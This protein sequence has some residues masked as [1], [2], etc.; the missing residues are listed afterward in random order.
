[1]DERHLVTACHVVEGDMTSTPTSSDEREY[2][3]AFPGQGSLVARLVFTNELVDLAVLE[4]EG[5]PGVAPS[6]VMAGRGLPPRADVF[7]FPTGEPET[8]GV[9]RKFVVSGPTTSGSRQLDWIGGYGTWRGMSGGSVIDPDSGALIGILIEGAAE[10][11]FDRF[12]PVPVIRA[13]WQAMPRPWSFAGL[14]ARAH[15]ER[16]STGQR[17]GMGSISLF[18]GRQAAL[19][20]IYFALDSHTGFGQPLVVTGQPGAGKSAVVTKAALESE[21]GRSGADLGEGL[22]FHARDAV[23]GELCRAVAQLLDLDPELL[24]EDLLYALG[25]LTGMPRVGVIVDALDE[26]SD[27]DRIAMARLLSDLARLPWIRVVVATRAMSET[28]RFAAG[29]LL[30][31]LGA[32]STEAVN[33]VDL[34][35]TPYAD[36]DALVGFVTALLTQREASHPT[37]R[38]GAWEEYRAESGFTDGIARAISA[39]AQGNFLVA[40][41]TADLLSQQAEVVTLHPSESDMLQIPGTIAEALDKFLD[42]LDVRARTS[43]LTLLTA[44][45]YARGAGVTDSGWLRFASALGHPADAD[46]LASLR[47]SAAIDFLV[48][49]VEQ[50]A[51][52]PT[53][54]LFHQALADELLARRGDRVLDDQSKI[55]DLLMSAWQG[56]SQGPDLDPYLPAHLAVHAARARHAARLLTNLSRDA[57][58][59]C[60]APSVSTIA[61]FHS[62]STVLASAEM[63]AYEHFL[64]HHESA[65]PVQLAAY[66][67]YKAL[68]ADALE[69]ATSAQRAAVNSPWLPVWADSR[70]LS[71]HR[72]LHRSR[73]A[74]AH[75]CAA[76]TV[77]T[78]VVVIAERDRLTVRDL[79]YGQVL[80]QQDWNPYDVAAAFVGHRLNVASSDMK[81]RV[82]VWPDF[83]RPIELEA[84][85]GDHPQVAVVE[86][87]AGPVF[88][89]AGELRGPDGKSAGSRARAWDR[90]GSPLWELPLGAGYPRLAP[91]VLASTPC[92]LVRRY[93]NEREERSVLAVAAETGT[94]VEEWATPD[95]GAADFQV[96][97]GDDIGLRVLTSE[98]IRVSI[99]S[100][101]PDGEVERLSASFPNGHEPCCV[102]FQEAAVLVQPEGTGLRFLDPRDLSDLGHVHL[103]VWTSQVSCAQDPNGG[104]ALLTTHDDGSVRR[105]A[106]DEL[107]ALAEPGPPRIEAAPTSLSHSVLHEH[108]IYAGNSDRT[109]H[110]I[111]ENGESVASATLPAMTSRLLDVAV[112]AG[113]RLMA[114]CPRV[115]VEL[116]PETLATVG[117]WEGPEFD[118]LEDFDVVTRNGRRLLVTAGAAPAR[119]H[120]YGLDVWTL[121]DMTHLSRMVAAAYLDKKPLA[122]RFATRHGRLVIVSGGWDGRVTVWDVEQ[123]PPP[124]NHND[125]AE[126]F[127]DEVARSNQSVRSI[128]VHPEFSHLVAAMGDDG[129][130]RI[131]DLDQGSE[132]EEVNRYAVSHAGILAASCIRGSQVIVGGSG[133]VLSAWPMTTSGGEVHRG[134]ATPSLSITL[135]SNIRDIVNVAGGVV[136]ATDQGAAQ[137]DLR[138]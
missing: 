25:A 138:V 91:C 130:V 44:L 20:A 46:A 34:D 9:W 35:A 36:R 55:A 118:G 11:G 66:L 125:I 134:A 33:L 52:E 92:V 119:P 121:D 45:A 86:T 43:A 95:V 131:I 88:I 124:A 129:F 89:S 97:P 16:R 75:I 136:V 80:G 81:G 59:L 100:L 108:F 42:R 47:A 63:R 67:R 71:R 103:G 21:R 137:L 102:P 54:A 90:S 3:V 6:A 58:F 76:S 85:C 41:L 72:V 135:G 56:R 79:S 82:L 106:L 65:E 29:S 23:V 112:P 93:T 96:L 127:P 126:R 17:G 99:L 57:E 123:L 116:D 60:L 24:P 70:S 40:A 8:R 37:P 49:T 61:S 69:L 105:W 83:W 48:R 74:R 98:F 109:V 50:Q 107:R 27:R 26:A 73:S 84:S 62:N 15:A 7:G 14:S 28:G 78:A 128:A 132:G 32:R 10:G 30:H 117:S 64:E 104:Y 22:M 5:D 12:V 87:D 101:L 4:I 38:G 110:R 94:V 68:L 114:I 111:D 51:S 53:T 120:V 18:R 19:T 77:G 13:K 122:A 39:R 1:M 133:G 31:A 2:E 115:M 113:S